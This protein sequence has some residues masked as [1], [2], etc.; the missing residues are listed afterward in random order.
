MYL[1]LKDLRKE[2][3]T[4]NLSFMKKLSG[5]CLETCIIPPGVGHGFYF[6]EAATHIYSVSEYWNLEDELGC[7]WNDNEIGLNWPA[8]NPLLSKRDQK[9]QSYENLMRE[10]NKHDFNFNPYEK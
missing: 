2:S 5:D 10:L 3:P 9:A 4:Y 6:A 1:G 7:I 8:G